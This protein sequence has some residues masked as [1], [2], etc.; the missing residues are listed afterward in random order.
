MYV[1]Y[2]EAIGTAQNGACIMCLVHIFKYELHMSR[3]MRNNFIEAVFALIR[4]ERKQVFGKFLP[5]GP[6]EFLYH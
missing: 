1:L 2:T 6:I 5:G 3:A 4:N